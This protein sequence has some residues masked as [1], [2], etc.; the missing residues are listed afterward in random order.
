M[1]KLH[2]IFGPSGAGKTT[3]ALTFAR[4]EGAVPLILDTWLANLFAPD[5]PDPLE[6]EW[7]IERVQRVEQQIWSTAA[8]C[9]RHAGHPRHRPD[10]PR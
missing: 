6:Y 7:M 5:M 8:A 2:V 10:D 3:Y 4:R 1:S 9:R